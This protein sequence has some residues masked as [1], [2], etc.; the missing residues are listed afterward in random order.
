M[1]ESEQEIH[2]MYMQQIEQDCFIDLAEEIEYPPTAI[3]MGRYSMS[4]KSGIKRYP[5]PIGTYGNF[6]F[7]SGQPKTKKSF[8]VSLLASVYLSEKGSNSYGGDLRAD[9]GDKCVVHFDTEQGKFHAQRV[10]RRPFEMN[11]TEN[12]GCYHT[13]GLRPIG[14]KTRIDFIE[15]KLKQLTEEGSDIGLVIIDGIADLVSDVNNIEESNVIVQKIMTWSSVYNCHIILVVHLNHNSE[16]STGHLGSFLTKKC[17]TE[18]LLT[19]NEGDDSIIG[20]KCK[21]SRNFSFKPFAFTVDK[22]GFPVVLDD[23]DVIVPDAPKQNNYQQKM[24]Y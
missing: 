10:F 24:R 3:S 13:Y 2:N 23:V 15:Y 9:R 17:E 6:S 8:L 18:M 7:I 11:K 20:V 19:A 16:K 21:R 22:L 12:L 1:T 4:T 5:I 14:Y